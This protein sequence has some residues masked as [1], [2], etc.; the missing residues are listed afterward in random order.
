MA[1]LTPVQRKALAMLG[2]RKRV[3]K[4]QRAATGQRLASVNVRTMPQ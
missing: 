2:W 3:E 1:L 4:Y